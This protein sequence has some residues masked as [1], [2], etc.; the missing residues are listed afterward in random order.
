MSASKSRFSSLAQAVKDRIADPE[1]R[2]AQHPR[3]SGPSAQ[4]STSQPLPSVQ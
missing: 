4:A 1:R 3:P 2:K